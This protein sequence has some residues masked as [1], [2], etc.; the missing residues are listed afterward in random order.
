M[1]ISV[2]FY[3]LE[4]DWDMQKNDYEKFIQQLKSELENRRLQSPMVN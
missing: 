2:C 1:Y 3:S 4:Q